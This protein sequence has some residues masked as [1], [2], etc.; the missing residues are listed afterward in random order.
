M[1][2]LFVDLMQKIALKLEWKI[3]YG[4]R[5]PYETHIS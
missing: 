3:G 1:L 5:K 2:G 4:L